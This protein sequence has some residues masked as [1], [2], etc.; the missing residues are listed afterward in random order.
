[1]GNQKRLSNSQPEIKSKNNQVGKIIIVEEDLF[2]SEMYVAK[3]ELEGFEIF[4]ASDGEEALDRMRL[5]KPDLVLL[6]LLMPKKDGLAVLKE[7]FND[8]E[9]KNIPVIVLTNLSQKE[10]INQCYDLGVKDFLIK[11]Y[12]IPSEVVRKIRNLIM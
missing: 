7:K 6:D 11:A 2:L 1:M 4:L 8:L 5:N 9:I 12:F 10:K 3:L